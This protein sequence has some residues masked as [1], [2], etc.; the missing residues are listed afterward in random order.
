MLARL[1]IRSRVLLVALLPAAALAIL[2]GIYFVTTGVNDLKKS[3]ATVGR[4]VA[5]ELAPASEYGVFSSN[6]RILRRLARAAL[7]EGNVESVEITDTDG[8][9]LASAARSQ[10][11]VPAWQR[12]LTAVLRTYDPTAAPL[13]FRVPIMLSAA[14]EDASAQLYEGDANQSDASAQTLGWVSV[15]LSEHELA[16]R[17]AEVILKGT[18]ITLLGLAAAL[19]LALRTGRTVTQPMEKITEAVTRVSDGELEVR[20]SE[21]SIGELGML[22][23]GINE[24][25]GAIQR[26]QASLQEQ[27]DRATAEL[28]ETLEAVE[29]KNVELDLARKRAIDANKVKSEFLANIS[30]EIRTPMN[31]ILG[32]TELMAKTPLDHDQREYLSTIEASADSLLTL[33]EDVLN[34]SRIEAGRV[35]VTRSSFALCSMIEDVV[36]LMAPAAFT[37]G[38]E[39]VDDLPCTREINLIADGSKL[40]QIVSNLLSNAIKF[41]DH[42]SVAIRTRL[43]MKDDDRAQLKLSVEDTGIGIDETGKKRLFQAFGQV[44]TSATRG[45]GGVGLGLVISKKLVDTLGGEMEFISS[46]GKGSCFTI[47]CPV[48][49]DRAAPASDFPRLPQTRVALYDASPLSAGVLE[50]RLQDWGCSVALFSRLDQLVDDFSRAAEHGRPFDITILSLSE[51]DARF[52]ENLHA[53]WKDLPEPPRLIA[54]VAS[55]DRLTQRRI[56]AIVGG[57]CLPKTAKRATLYQ[58]LA[59]T[60]TR[61]LQTESAGSERKSSASVHLDGSRLLL[62]ED[63]RISRRLASEQ[64][65]RLGVLITEAENGAEAI[66]LADSRPDLILLDLQLPDI[67]GIELARKLRAIPA[68][69]DV[70][71]FAFT[72]GEPEDAEA[73]YAAGIDDILLKPLSAEKLHAACAGGRREIGSDAEDSSADP[74][75]IKA[76]LD[77]LEPDIREMLVEDL[78]AQ[79][80]DIDQLLVRGDLTAARDVVHTL[81]GSAAFC[82]LED[83][84]EAA[85]ALESALIAKDEQPRLQTLFERLKVKARLIV[86]ELQR[87]TGPDSQVNQV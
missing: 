42:G 77:A 5:A 50:R 40:R 62:V 9:V 71:I 60:L 39:L 48:E 61:P 70:P 59:A 29:I 44:D 85:D 22:E 68:L 81:H 14:D 67:P 79:L 34:L 35:T 57:P 43:E 31:A 82:R 75:S 63:N 69:R 16:Y 53:L 1:G 86:A 6:Q 21:N 72:A 12:R 66:A 17:E 2:L 80:R 3:Q 54:L 30:H 84:R 49:L 55:P 25:A 78:P 10:P 19:I 33:L 74:N 8:K 20:V 24:M 18:L 46:P 65:K 38:L 73:L 15:T 7:R 28:R 27:V 52:P 4:A 45:H 47:T 56:A 36:T 58:E 37:K 13:R 11:M 32:F 26:A 51:I 87:G 64:L 23:R 76:A 41:T 83:L